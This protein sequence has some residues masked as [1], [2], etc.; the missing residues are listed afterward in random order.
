MK[1]FREYIETWIDGK[2]IRGI[3][4]TLSDIDECIYIYNSIVK[5][6]KPEFINGKVKD[7]LDKCG[8]NTV[9]CGIGWKIA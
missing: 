5:K 1:K 3:N 9:T 8:I 4:V 7:I 6:K 2:N